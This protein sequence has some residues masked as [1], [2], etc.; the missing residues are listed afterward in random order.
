MSTLF[1]GWK[2][3]H[4]CPA[5]PVV[6]LGGYISV[7]EEPPAGL[8]PGAWPKAKGVSPPKQRAVIIVAVQNPGANRPRCGQPSDCLLTWSGWIF[9]RTVATLSPR[10]V[11]P[12]RVMQEDLEAVGV[13][14]P[15]ASV[16]SW[17]AIR[18]GS[19]ARTGRQARRDSQSV[20]PVVGRFSRSCVCDD[21]SDTNAGYNADDDIPAL[22]TR[23]DK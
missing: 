5:F 1:G 15:A 11:S 22:A 14:P 20:P 19:P 4:V 9:Q 10:N 23:P 13:T 18:S 21:S 2:L 16:V 3:G 12:R 17:A 8:P 6:D 7:F